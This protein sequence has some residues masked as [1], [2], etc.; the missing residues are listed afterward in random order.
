MPF[1]GE[2][3]IW[4]MVHVIF[5]LS[6]GAELEFKL[7]REQ[8][9]Q[10][11]VGDQGMNGYLRDKN[12][13]IVSCASVLQVLGKFKYGLLTYLTTSFANL[14]GLVILPTTYSLATSICWDTQIVAAMRCMRICSCWTMPTKDGRTRRAVLGK[15][16]L[17]SNSRKNT[18]SRTR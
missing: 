18:G 4:K 12:E 17:N 2:T 1:A 3:I 16:S 7:K 15:W 9:A 6:I 14:V 10:D 11:T 13:P 5:L 8:V